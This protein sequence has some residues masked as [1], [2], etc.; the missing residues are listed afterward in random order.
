MYDI[1]KIRQDFPIL[2]RKINGKPLVY[3]DNAATSQKPKQVLESI[4]R[5][6]EKHNANIHRGVHTLSE[7]SSELYDKAHRKVGEFINAEFPSQEIV[8]LR[9][10]TEGINLVMY[11]WASQN[12]NKGDE[13]LSTVMEH[14]SNFVPWQQL[15]KKGIK[16]RYVDINEEGILDI[17]DIKKKITKKTKLVTCIHVSNV[18]GTINP[19]KEIGEI[20]HKAGA[21]FLL[22]AAQSVPHMSVDVRE[23]NCDFMV[24]SGHKML[25]PTGIGVLYGKKHLLEKMSPF[26][27]GGDM[28]KEVTLTNSTWNTLPWKFEA[29]TPN[30]SG[31]I[32]L[33]VAV[34]YLKRIGMKNVEK[35]VSSLVEYALK[36][37]SELGGIE[38]YG[39]KNPRLRSGLISFDVKGIHPHDVA[40]ILN[41][42]FA[43]AV[44]SGYHCAQ[45]L[46]ERLN[47]QTST[48]AS[49]YLYNTK[50]EIEVLIKGLKKVKEVFRK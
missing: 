4:K 6:Y 17:E 45:P 16:I 12:L 48:R 33:G 38:I 25:G 30:I 40:T 2:N 49:F 14:H 28:I 42:E 34:E 3:L 21:M 31:G 5:Y 36:G 23:I 20:A 35:H 47:T 26:L 39:P 24:F 1:K 8:F 37:V 43:V 32:G 19:A 46:H 9:N 41:S 11:S 50:E 13:I 44:R 15:R 7:E 22:D 27:F 18:L 10:A 29:G